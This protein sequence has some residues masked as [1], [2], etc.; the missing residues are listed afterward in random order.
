MA[1]R[2]AARA[3]L[4]AAEAD[5]RQAEIDLSYTEIRAPFRGRVGRRLVDM[6]NL[7]GAGD[8]TL[9]TTIEQTKPMYAYFDVNEQIVLRIQRLRQEYADKMDQLEPLKVFLGLADEKGCPHEGVLDFV[10]NAVDPG[11][12]TA[13]IRGVFPNE[14]NLLYP[15]LFVRLRVPGKTMENALLVHERALGT[16][17]EGKYLMLVGPDDEGNDDIVEKRPVVTGPLIDG[18]R[19]IH[20]GISAGER[21]ILKGLQR[22]RPGLPVRPQEADAA[23][24]ETPA[25]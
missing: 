9:L 12:G 21:Y 5:I 20:E 19:V 14:D 24:P 18:M 10:E 13:L 23:P 8:A 4:A 17:L 7:V 2:D 25:D 11:T 22:A 6:D 16:D 3:D 1:H 15:G